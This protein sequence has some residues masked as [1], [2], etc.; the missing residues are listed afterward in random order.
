MANEALLTADSKINR[1]KYFIAYINLLSNSFD[2][3]PEFA[4]NL[5][6]VPRPIQFQ[7]FFSDDHFTIREM[8]VQIAN[9]VSS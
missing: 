3:K 7:G 2:K 5:F 9:L 4:I 6:T 1:Y 8:K